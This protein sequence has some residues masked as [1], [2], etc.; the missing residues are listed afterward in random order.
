MMS[1]RLVL[2]VL[3]VL[4]IQG[5]CFS[6]LAA[7]TVEEVNR[8]EQQT[9]F[10]RY[11]GSSVEHYRR[12]SVTD[13]Q[14][15]TGSLKTVNGIL[16]V[17]NA[18]RISGELYQITYRI[19]SGYA[20]QEVFDYYRTLIT[21]ADGRIFYE[22]QARECGASNLWANR[23]FKVAKLYGPDQ[24]Q[25]YQAAIVNT[26]NGMF[27]VATYSIQR[28]NR[29]VYQHLELV[30]LVDH[31]LAKVSVNPETILTILRQDGRWILHELEFDEKNQLKS[32][33][34]TLVSLAEVMMKDV[35]LMIY[36]VGHLGVAHNMTTK[37]AIALS[38]FRAESVK[39][40]LMAAGVTAERIDVYG[41][42]P[43]VPFDGEGQNRDRI[44]AVL[45]LH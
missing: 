1:P 29:R 36:L 16:Q 30:K 3:L 5:F 28:G 27:A 31:G 35:R 4:A 2:Q 9:G 6:L 23:V 34:P 7:D 8:I 19:P 37:E 14:W 24:Y 38:K 11:P 15:V 26:E 33:Q 20:P 18:Q 43:L 13:H 12:S 17:D 39:Q 22:C 10:V 42:G 21:K 44:E 45:K 32:A 40:R 25:H 41:V